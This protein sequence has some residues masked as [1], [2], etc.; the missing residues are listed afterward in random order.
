MRTQA[1]GKIVFVVPQAAMRDRTE[2]QDRCKM[3]MNR[4]ANIEASQRFFPALAPMQ[5]HATFGRGVEIIRLEL[6]GMLIAQERVIVATEMQQPAAEAAPQFGTVGLELDRL[7]EGL[8]RLVMALD[9]LQHG[10]EMLQIFRFRS[11]P[12]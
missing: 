7:V 8:Q 2:V 3:G 10:A 6:E 5:Q 12:D 11:L 9:V 1:V 4:K